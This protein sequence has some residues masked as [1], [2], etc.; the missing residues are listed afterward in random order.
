MTAAEPDNNKVADAD[1][2]S[3]ESN[4]CNGSI[5][6]GGNS[7]GDVSADRVDNEKSGSDVASGDEAHRSKRSAADI[8]SVSGD[9]MPAKRRSTRFI[10]RANSAVASGTGSRTVKIL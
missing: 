4:A 3:D 5:T 1:H 7:A 9:E 10:E 8:E 6:A 2:V